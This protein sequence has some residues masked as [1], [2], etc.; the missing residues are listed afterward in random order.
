MRRYPALFKVTYRK[1]PH[2]ALPWE[3]VD[4][5]TAL[6]SIYAGRKPSR[7][8]AFLVL[9]ILFSYQFLHQNM[10]LELTGS[11]KSELKQLRA[12]LL[13]ELNQKAVWQL[14]VESI[15][16]VEGHTT[17]NTCHIAQMFLFADAMTK[18][19]HEDWRENLP[20]LR[21]WHTGSPT[22]IT[23]STDIVELD[24]LCGLVAHGE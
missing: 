11:Q 23:W 1:V 19:S 21:S 16:K 24:Q 3:A 20:A 14:F 2:A 6:S 15:P 13:S 7:S 5:R 17:F 9:I 4:R 18:M 8:F 12:I 22:A 10:A